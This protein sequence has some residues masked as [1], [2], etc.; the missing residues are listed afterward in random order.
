[1]WKGVYDIT[2]ASTYKVA[3][4]TSSSNVSAAS[5]TWAGVTGEVSNGNGYTTGG[6]AVTMTVSG[7]TTMTV[8]ATGL[9][10]WTATGGSIT[11]ARTAVL[12]KVGG[13]VIA[14]CALDTTA[15]GSDV[16]AATGENITLDSDG[17]PS[18]IFTHG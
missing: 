8:S 11:G 9:L 16:T 2:A 15:G 17:T 4:V 13:N 7:T 18:P 1:L 14:T 3:L 6:L 10:V 5:T 12:Y